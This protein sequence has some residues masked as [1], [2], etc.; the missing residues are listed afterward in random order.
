MV[1]ELSKEKREE[2]T[3]RTYGCSVKG[4]SGWFVAH[5]P[6][7]KHTIASLKPPKEGEDAITRTYHCNIKVY[8]P[9]ETTL[10]WYTEAGPILRSG[11]ARVG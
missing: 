6:D 8:P 2:E 4:C 11:F 1:N 5:P 3:K 10:Y 7:D 9:H